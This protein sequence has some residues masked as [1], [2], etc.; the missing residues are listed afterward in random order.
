MAKM[1]YVIVG[2]SIAAATALNVLRANSPGTAVHVVADEAVPFYYRALIPYLIDESRTVEDILFT[3]QPSTDP[4]VRLHHDRCVAVDPERRVVGLKSGKELTYDKLL[5]AAGSSPIQPDIAGIDSEGVFTLRTL[6]D[7][8]KIR[9]YLK[10]CRSAAVIGGALA[11]IKVA[12]ALLRTELEVTVVEQRPHIL[13]NIADAAVAESIT[14]RLRQRGMDILIKDPALEIISSDGGVTG[15]RLASGKTVAADLVVLMAGVRPNIDFLNGSG[16][17]MQQGVLTNKKMQTSVPDVY[18]VGDMVQ[19]Y[20]PVAKKDVVSA[21][22]GNAV[23]MGRV[24]GFNM[25]GIEAYVPPLLS[26]LNSTEIADFPVISAGLLHSRSEEYEVYAEV[27]GEDYR[28]LVF[29]EDRLVGMLF[30]GNVN[31]AG[32]YTNLIRNRIPLG[33]RRDA[34]IREVMG[35]IG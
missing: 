10:G 19:F 23:H 32:V 24:A 17:E 29:D 28:K 7:A 13:P 35:E 15:V 3:E 20:D 22:W 2:G 14:R 33:D 31:R 1:E 9:D 18:A 12:E 5:L 4:A 27:R 8:V 26:S 11:G 16:I 25:S 6:D 21:L 30:L 34:L